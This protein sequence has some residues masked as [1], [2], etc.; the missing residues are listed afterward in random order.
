MD[1]L[2]VSAL[3][4]IRTGAADNDLFLNFIESVCPFMMM[5]KTVLVILQ[6]MKFGILDDF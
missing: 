6:M 2:Y 3:L 1:E 5:G 4:L